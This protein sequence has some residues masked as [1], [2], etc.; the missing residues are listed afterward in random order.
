M[1]AAGDRPLRLGVIGYSEGNGHPFSY[2]AIVNGYDDEAFGRTGWP[3]IHDYLRAKDAAQFGFPGVG[4]THVWMPDGAMA[5]ALSEACRIP[6]VAARPEDMLGEVDAVLIL[7]DD[8]E[9]HWPTASGFLE[10]GM[11]VF[12]DKPLTLDAAELDWF[13]P[14]LESG[15]LMSCAGLRF[16]A[17]LAP[18]RA[19]GG[20]DA[21]GVILAAECAV[22]NDWARYGI[23]M[24]E[25]VM[26]VLRA[27][28]VTIQRLP[29]AT[30]AM[31]VTLDSGVLVTINA[32]GKSPKLFEL[33]LRGDK[34][35]QR[36]QLH[37]NFSAFRGVLTGFVE[38]LRSGRP[39]IAPHETLAVI[40]TIQAGLAAEPGGPAVA[41]RNP[42][43][44]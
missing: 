3:V 15:R 1:V 17:E 14:Y 5:W 2:S 8:P 4:V 37:D 13:A 44:A 36:F 39:A 40:Q 7:R 38:Q 25:A 42:A 6:N 18:L 12:V 32:L 9:T 23:H 30:E 29:G 16:A 11:A 35:S 41:I 21:L 19:R 26:G 33:T 28:P 20:L 34:G 24:L 27:R 22:L 31:A 43:F 10:A